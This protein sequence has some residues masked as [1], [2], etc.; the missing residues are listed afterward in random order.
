MVLGST[1]S[2]RLF[3]LST[4]RLGEAATT[5]HEEGEKASLQDPS[6]HELFYR[7]GVAL[8]EYGS[9]KKCCSTLRRANQNFKQATDLHPLYCEAWHAWAS[10]L[11]LLS[12]LSGNIDYLIDEQRKKK[13][14]K[15]KQWLIP[16]NKKNT[17][18][19]PKLQSVRLLQTNHQPFAD[20]F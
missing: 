19:P 12:T 20:Q 1:P 2:P 6:S 13:K 5:L 14:K 10:S 11:V 17:R 16:K 18:Y 4:D 7:Q 3:D 9:Q 15:L 8:F